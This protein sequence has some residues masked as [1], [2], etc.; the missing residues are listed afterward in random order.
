MVVIVRVSMEEE[1][2]GGGGGSFY[3]RHSMTAAR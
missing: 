1:E 2:D 3:N